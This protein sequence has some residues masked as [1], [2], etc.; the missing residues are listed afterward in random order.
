[1]SGMSRLFS[2]A[3]LK[4]AFDGIG[5]GRNVYLCELGSSLHFESPKMGIVAFRLEV[6][7]HDDRSVRTGFLREEVKQH[8]VG[9]VAE[10][11]GPFTII[12]AQSIKQGFLYEIFGK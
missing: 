6:G 5:A 10:S 12:P 1:M 8:S 2:G 9:G 3:F 7:F 11:T 4:T